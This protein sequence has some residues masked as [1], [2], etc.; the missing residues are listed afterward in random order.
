MSNLHIF[1]FLLVKNLN[2]YNFLTFITQIV[3]LCPKPKSPFFITKSIFYIYNLYKYDFQI[4]NLYKYS[5]YKFSLYKIYKVRLKHIKTY[6][7][8]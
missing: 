8:F 1:S 4:Y 7:H 6:K 3:S 5:L 2:F